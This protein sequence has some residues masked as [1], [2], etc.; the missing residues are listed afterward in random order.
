MDYQPAIV[1]QLPP[2]DQLLPRV[3]Q[4]I[5]H[6][7]RTGL[8]VIYVVAGF[9]PGAPEMTSR[10]RQQFGHL[11]A[12]EFSQVVPALAPQPGEL[13]V[14]KRRVSAFS[15]SDLEI[16]LRQLGVRHLVLAGIA[17][18]G[19][20]LSTLCEAHDQDYQLT[21]LADACRDR[22]PEVHEVLLQKVFARRGAVLPVASWTAAP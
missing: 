8:P 19:V 13:T 3:A 1:Q 21:V 5:A 7:R 14:V 2:D 4:A 17:T 20:V 9:R 18:S 16:V 12:A 10:V 15:G 22:D 6:A 11:D